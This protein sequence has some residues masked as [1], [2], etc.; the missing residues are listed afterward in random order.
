VSLPTGGLVSVELRRPDIDEPERFPYT[1]PAI[2]S[3]RRLD[4]SAPVTFFVGENGSGKSTLLEAMA[5]AADLNPEGG[6]RHLRF[7][8]RPTESALHEHLR[9]SWRTRQRWGFF[10]RAET[11][12]GT[13]SAYDEVDG[14]PTS[15]HD[16]SHGEQ[17]ID[18]AMDKLE[19][20]GFHLLDEPESALSV[21][22][23]LKLLR[24]M[25]DVVEGG[26]QFVIATHSPIL[27]AFP[28]ARI[29]QF[30]DTIA[31]V[32]YEESQ[33]YLLTS[34]FLDAPDR[35]LRHLFDDDDNEDDDD[36]DPD[37]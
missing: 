11:F 33:P 31:P 22:G 32:A 10:L 5:I 35:F 26:G 34:S 8:T 7:S 25:H 14:L 17:F 4:L 15:L 23:Q 28:G 27:S 20:G 36:P 16:R 29:Y 18:I 37:R 12:F 30:D 1:I 13:L 24:R 19:P 3:L 9:L 2:A 21:V 6:S